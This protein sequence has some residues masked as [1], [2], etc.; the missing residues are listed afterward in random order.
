[1]AH[2]ALSQHLGGLYAQALIGAGLTAA[3]SLSLLF[4]P[5]PWRVIRGVG[6]TAGYSWLVTS[7]LLVGR[8]EVDAGTVLIGSLVVATFA[9]IWLPPRAAVPL[10]AAGY[11]ALWAPVLGPPNVPALLAI[12]VV[13]TQL[14]YLSTHGR[15]VQK[16]RI[17]NELLSQMAFTDPLTGLLNRRS[18][19]E[20]LQ[21]LME[22]AR[23]RP[24]GTALVLLDIDHFKRINDQLGHHRGDEVLM[25]VAG[26]LS[27]HEQVQAAAR[28][29]GEEFLVVCGAPTRHA[30]VATAEQLVAQ[31]RGLV[32]P[33]FPPVTVSG[34]LAT[35][36]EAADL[37]DLLELADT[38]M[39]LA[40]HQGRNRLVSRE[41]GQ[42]RLSS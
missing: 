30:A 15:A 10:A 7:M 14:W 37:T 28:W 19:L 38:R 24:E 12:A 22:D 33:G 42:V 2:R 23:L 40:K 18:M 32:L 34:G 9:F 4:T 35:F 31:V 6:L 13:T 8:G 41:D 20:R 36:Q 3:L 21:Q 25:A 39:Y 11:A 27:R 29:G 16:E 5:L 17:R 26:C 1:M